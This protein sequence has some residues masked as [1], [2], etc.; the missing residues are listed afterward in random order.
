MEDNILQS[1][2]IK[3][4]HFIGIGGI[5]MSGLAEILA[6]LGYIISGS[7]LNQSTITDKLKTL[8][9]TV[10]IGHSPEHIK[11]PDLVVYTAAIGDDNPELVKARSLNIKTINRATLLGE[12]MKKYP[13][14]IGVSGTHGKTTT[15]SMI[16]LIMLKS[17]L[18]PTIHIGGQLDYIGGTTRTGNTGYFVT[19]ACEYRDSFL[20]FYPYIA[21]ILNIDLDH[22]DYFKDI[23][24]IKDSFV[25]FVSRVPKNGYVIA[26][27]DDNNIVSIFGKIA[28]PVITFGLN[29]KNCTWSAEDISFDSKGCPSFTVLKDGKAISSIN[30]R[31]PG[32]HNIYNAL[33]A[34]A[35]CHQLGCSISSIKEGL[36]MYTGTHRR[37]EHKGAYNGAK[38]VDDYAHHPSEVKATLK[39]AKSSSYSKIW[40][41][42]QPH[43]YT[44]TKSLLNDFASSFNNADVVIVT[45]IYAAREKDNGEIN[46]RILTEE[47]NRVSGNAIYMDDFNNIANFLKN[48]VSPGD[49]IITMGAGDIFKVG[50]ILLKG[51][52]MDAKSV[53]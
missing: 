1:D 12:I 28:A 45:D 30:L 9:I 11:N 48:N 4:I 20:K 15:T 35:A 10:Y 44:R 17:N 24:Q 38:I 7:D 19:E 2:K 13:Y 6:S 16:S 21:V 39:A 8:G 52:L 22:I 32:T 37:F 51:N 36:Y 31:V 25:K 23:E 49:I 34:I 27:G 53:V 40:C 5:S 3:Y 29:N 26:C 47:I 18:D 14:S 46:S 50:D 41:V 43:T 42:F 33:A